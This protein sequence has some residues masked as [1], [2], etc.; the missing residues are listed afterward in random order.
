ML[1][2]PFYGYLEK[3]VLISNLCLLMYQMQLI[4][5]NLSCVLILFF[6]HIYSTYQSA[7]DEDSFFYCDFIVIIVIAS[8]IIFII[9]SVLISEK[10]IFWILSLDVI[11]YTYYF[12]FLLLFLPSSTLFFPVYWEN[13]CKYELLHLGTIFNSGMFIYLYWYVHIFI[14][15]AKTGALGVLVFFW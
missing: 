1:W 8:V 14:L 4:L 12:P 6:L 10:K 11:N 2:V 13:L 9:V 15:T 3:I 7:E 5:C